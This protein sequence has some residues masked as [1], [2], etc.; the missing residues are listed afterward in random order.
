[1][2]ETKRVALITG[3]ARG[4]GLATAR[5]FLREGYEVGLLDNDSDTL[6]QAASQLNNHG[7]VLALHCDVAFPAQVAQA[8]AQL[9]KAFGRLYQW[10]NHCR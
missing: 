6:E 5:R 3:A 8:I 1:M 10:S 2:S 9:D 7:D 4:I